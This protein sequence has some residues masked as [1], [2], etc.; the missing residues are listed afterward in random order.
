VHRGAHRKGRLDPFNE[1]PFHELLFSKHTGG[2]NLH[3]R[4]SQVGGLSATARAYKSNYTHAQKTVDVD[5]AR[6]ERAVEV[7]HRVFNRIILGDEINQSVD[8]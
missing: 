1:R 2:L 8:V 7:I 5:A 3:W 6:V 4:A